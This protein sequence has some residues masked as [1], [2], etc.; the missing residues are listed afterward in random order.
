MSVATT[1][2]RARSATATRARG[3]ARRALAVGLA[4]MALAGC[5]ATV[6]IRD[7]LDDP[8]T[9]D[10]RKVKIE[11][12]VGAAASAFGNGAYMVD[13]GTGTLLVVAER[14]KGVPHAGARVAVV[15]WFRSLLDFG[16]LSAAVVLERGRSAREGPADPP[17]R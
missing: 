12:D 5:R 11:G 2:A 3:P 16:P 13:D 7:L 10:R 14:R 4:A 6:P 8:Y 1:N 17:R 15:G 9:Y